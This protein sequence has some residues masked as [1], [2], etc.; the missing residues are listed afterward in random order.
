MHNHL[1]G[2]L[3][4]NNLTHGHKFLRPSSNPVNSYIEYKKYL[5]NNFV[6]LD[7]K[8][9]KKIIQ[10]ILEKLANDKNLEIVPDERLL[11]EVT[12]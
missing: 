9:R 3:K 7:Q 8:E 1:H 10:E 6:V 11:E 2:H 4:S 5:E 12:G